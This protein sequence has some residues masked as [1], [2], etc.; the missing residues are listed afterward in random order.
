MDVKSPVK[1]LVLNLDSSNLVGTHTNEVWQR[2]GMRLTI[3]QKILIKTVADS[4]RANFFTR[5]RIE[6]R[7]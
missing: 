5:I 3:I 7:G 4:M 2:L 1:S 6:L